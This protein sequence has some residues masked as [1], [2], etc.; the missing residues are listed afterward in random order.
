[1]DQVLELLADLLALLGLDNEYHEAAAARAQQLAADRAGCAAGLVD[2]VD[3]LFDTLSA[4]SRL[5]TPGLDA[6]VRR[7]RGSV[8][9]VA[10]NIDRTVHH[11]ANGAK[12]RSC[13]CSIFLIWSWAKSL[14]KREKPVKNSIMD[15]LQL[16]APL[17]AASMIGDTANSPSGKKS[18]RLKPP[19][20]AHS[21][22]WR[23]DIFLQHI[24]LDADRLTGRDRACQIILPSS[25]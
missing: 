8:F 16:L 2:L 9:D 11:A 23:A 4:S 17:L 19:K 1:M 7:V 6:A 22:S 18:M 10:Q 3:L 20:A 14:A 5:S 25:A 12:L 21:W 13:D 15:C 24:L